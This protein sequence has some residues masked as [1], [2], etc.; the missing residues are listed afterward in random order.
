MG[1]SADDSAAACRKLLMQMILQRKH[2]KVE[3]KGTKSEIERGSVCTVC[4]C[5]CI[6]RRLYYRNSLACAV[7][8][9]ASSLSRRTRSACAWSFGLAVLASRAAS[10]SLHS[11][12][13]SAA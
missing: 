8:R 5:V 1:K 3:H 7:R 9:D 13:L 12:I 4:V 11:P 6:K 2:G 10:D